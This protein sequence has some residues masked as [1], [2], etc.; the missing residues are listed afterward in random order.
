V[1]YGTDSQ[2]DVFQP[3]KTFGA[4]YDHRV[5]PGQNLVVWLKLTLMGL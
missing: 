3:R 4:G 2:L 5:P 1:P